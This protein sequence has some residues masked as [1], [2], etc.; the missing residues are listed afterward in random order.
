MAKAKAGTKKPKA[1]KPQQSESARQ[2]AQ[3]QLEF[4][5]LMQSPEQKQASAD[6]SKFGWIVDRLEQLEGVL[7][8]GKKPAVGAVEMLHGLAT[9]REQSGLREP[10]NMPDLTV[11]MNLKG[12]LPVLYF[13]IC[14]LLD[15]APTKVE[16]D[17][18]ECSTKFAELTAAAMTG[19]HSVP[20]GGKRKKTGTTSVPAPQSKRWYRYVIFWCVFIDSCELNLQRA[21]KLLTG[22]KGNTV[23]SN[24]SKMPRPSREIL[25]KVKGD[26]PGKD[27]HT[28]YDDPIGELPNL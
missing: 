14:K 13:G 4:D 8:S 16:L 12:R 22:K 19:A 25:A 1:R 23:C 20:D 28:V 2:D 5:Y 18:D 7:A 17:S 21:A 15:V 11:A 10:K 24:F 3:D 26:F 27:L 6:A 9:M